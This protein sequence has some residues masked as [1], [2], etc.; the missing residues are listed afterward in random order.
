MQQRWPVQNFEILLSALVNQAPTDPRRATP[1]A[2]P[3]VEMQFTTIEYDREG[4]ATRLSYHSCFRT[5][6][7][8]ADYEKKA[9]RAI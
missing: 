3:I 6:L 7:H 1:M 4:Q 2:A 5:P 9:L 8:T